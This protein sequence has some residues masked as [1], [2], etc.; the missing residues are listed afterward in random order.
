LLACYLLR[1]TG[2]IW[3][4]APPVPIAGDLAGVEDDANDDKPEMTAMT[5]MTQ[6]TAN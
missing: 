6:M 1:P 3:Y 2:P 5:E 4:R